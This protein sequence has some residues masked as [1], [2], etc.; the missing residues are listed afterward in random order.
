MF[1]LAVI[2]FWP[3]W[4][5]YCGRMLDGS[6]DPWGA[7]AV[8]FAI[9]LKIL[10]SDL[11]Q[12]RPSQ[13][14][15]FVA[16]CLIY[17]LSFQLLPDLPRAVLAVC[18]IATLI[19]DGRR[20]DL[21]F[22]ALLLLSLPLIA[23][24]EFFL[25]Y[26]VRLV[27]SHVSAFVIKLVCNLNIHADGTL[28]SLDGKLVAIDSP[29]S[30]V[31]MLWVGLFAAMAWA[32]YLKLSARFTLNLLSY[33]LKVIFLANLT[34]VIVLFFKESTLVPL[35]EWTHSALGLLLFAFATTAISRRSL[36]YSNAN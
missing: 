20:G 36:R 35:P 19:L 5:W 31:K 17:V 34:R 18:A 4:H 8:F 16:I 23:S 7:A 29:C 12:I 9:T 21:A 2:A 33:S 3:V 24:L 22:L 6:D 30:G 11:R 14:Y 27:L 32:A 25:G 26:P 13:Q 28:L 1:A 10:H 15:A